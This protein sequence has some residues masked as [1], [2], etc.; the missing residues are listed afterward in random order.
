MD[1]G[2]GGNGIAGWDCGPTNVGSTCVVVDTGVGIAFCCWWVVAWTVGQ[3]LRVGVAF[4][5]SGVGAT[6]LAMRVGIVRVGSA[7]CCCARR[8]CGIGIGCRDCL[9]FL[10]VRECRIAGLLYKI[11]GLLYKISGL[12][13][14]KISG[15]LCIKISGLLCMRFAV[16]ERGECEKMAW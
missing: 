9:S 15:L 6:G 4:C 12:L 10:L 8:E 2:I 7:F 14:I 13:C 11:A 5:C 16:G 3:G 1:N